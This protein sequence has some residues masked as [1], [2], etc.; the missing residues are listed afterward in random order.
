MII[1]LSLLHK[2]YS[3]KLKNAK[4]QG[5]KAKFFRRQLVIVVT[6]SILFGLGWGVGLI[7]TEEIYSNKTVRDLFASLFVILTAFHGLFTF[8]MHCVRSREVRNVWKRLL[9]GMTGRD[10]SEFSS[11]TFNQFR[12][13]GSSSLKSTGK[14]PL[15]EDGHVTL[16]AYSK[17]KEAEEEEEEIRGVEGQYAI[18]D[19]S[20]TFNEGSQH[21]VKVSATESQ[22][23]G[24]QKS[25]TANGADDAKEGMPLTDDGN[26]NADLKKSAV[27]SLLEE[28]NAHSEHA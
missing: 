21:D 4:T 3:S 27:L 23:L 1:V 28:S 26:K 22:C 24:S 9:C 15:S 18:Q 19:S 13:R 10:F 25:I 6:L 5:S 2:K 12:G 20:M 17:K 7:V 11:S 16:Q 14:K 8:L